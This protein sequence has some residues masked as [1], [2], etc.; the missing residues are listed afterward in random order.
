L[1][2]DRPN[3][4]AVKQ[5]LIHALQKLWSPGERGAGLSRNHPCQAVTDVILS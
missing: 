1:G 5:T 4:A 3:M 2:Q